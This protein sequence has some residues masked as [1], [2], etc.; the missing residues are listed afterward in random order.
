[1]AESLRSFRG[2]L[3]LLQMAAEVHGFLRDRERT[4]ASVESVARQGLIDRLWLERLARC[5]T[6]SATIRASR[7][8]TAEV[9]GRRDEIMAGLPAP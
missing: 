8:P 3:Y 9:A 1:V 2:R 7:P 6:R 4:L 5:S